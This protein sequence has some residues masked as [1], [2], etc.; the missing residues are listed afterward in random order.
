MH[1]PFSLVGFE[2]RMHILFNDNQIL[3]EESP[4]PQQICCLFELRMAYKLEIVQSI[5]NTCLYGLHF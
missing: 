3:I 5:L 2:A 4:P 1:V